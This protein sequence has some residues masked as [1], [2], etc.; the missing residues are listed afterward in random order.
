MPG[1]GNVP[2]E[3]QHLG[4]EAGLLC[5]CVGCVYIVVRLLLILLGVVW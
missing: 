2:L 4:A 5:L 1:C 3:S